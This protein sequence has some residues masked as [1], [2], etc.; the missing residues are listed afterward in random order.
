LSSAP[1][2]SLFLLHLGSNA[3]YAI[4]PLETLFYE[5]GKDIAGG[6]AMRVHFGY[7][8]LDGGHPR[9]LP[10]DFGNVIAFDFS[11]TT[12]GNLRRLAAYVERHGIRL[13]VI[14]DIQ[15]V[16]P[17]FRALRGAGV[18]TVLGYWGASIS[19][20]MPAW[21]L[22]LK[23]LQMATSRSKVDGLIFESQAMADLAVYGRGVRRDMIDVVPLG[24]DIAR[25]HPER[26]DYAH[27]TLAIPTDRRIVV[28][29]GHME[30]RKGVRTL[31]E[32]AIELLHERGRSD[33]SFLLCG[34]TGDQSH[35]YERMYAGLGIAEWIRFGGYRRDLAELYRS[36]FCG[37]IPS[38]GWDSFTFASVEMAA[39]GL[40]IVASRLQGLP[41][42][43]LNGQTGLLFE[44]GNAQALAD[45]LETLLDR[46]EVA[47]EYG[48]RGRERCERELN[49]DVQRERFLAVVRR[50]LGAQRGR[51]DPVASAVILAPRD[52]SGSPRQGTRQPM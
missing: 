31:V 23:R 33:V 11:D 3:G 17:L 45:C 2:S 50:R 20:R 28:Y 34:N 30:P 32:A 22:A 37:V 42:A 40:P 44:P 6:D 26:S 9:A 46:P 41:E 52:G 39:T 4:S 38:T 10:P 1:I 13:A 43:V 29:A 16:H 12:P 49:R 18:T 47:A 25:F 5:V 35:E 27:R 36:C 51:E 19:S 21:K 15:P 8:R 48:R 7:C 14:F 24:V